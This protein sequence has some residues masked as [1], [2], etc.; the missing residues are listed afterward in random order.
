MDEYK[1]LTVTNADNKKLTR[2]IH[3]KICVDKGEVKLV[4]N[5]WVEPQIIYLCESQDPR[6]PVKDEYGYAIHPYLLVELLKEED[7]IRVQRDGESRK[8]GFFDNE[9]QIIN[10]GDPIPLGFKRGEESPR[11][12]AGGGPTP[13]ILEPDIN[14]RFKIQVKGRHKNIKVK[15]REDEEDEEEEEVRQQPRITEEDIREL[16]HL[17]PDDEIQFR[18]VNQILQFLISDPSKIKY[19]GELLNINGWS[20]EDTGEIEEISGASAAGSILHIYNINKLPA[21][22]E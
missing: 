13:F 17:V 5:Q 7:E 9:D 16:Q 15:L 8:L 19:I 6:I 20:L 11:V 10:D 4:Q 3:P 12:G 14:S 22:E 1:W 18:I 21:E 2:F